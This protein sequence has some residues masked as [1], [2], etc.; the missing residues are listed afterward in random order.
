VNVNKWNVDLMSISG[1]KVYEP[2]GVG[3]CFVQRRPH[4]RLDPIITRGGQE[5]GLRSGTLASPLVI[6]IGKACEIAKEK[7]E[8]IM[9]TAFSLVVS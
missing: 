8:V 5:R 3:A 6:G 7:L 4:I 2:K 1:Y 9:P